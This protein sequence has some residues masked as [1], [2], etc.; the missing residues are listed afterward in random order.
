MATGTLIDGYVLAL[1]NF[2][3]GLNYRSAV[4]HGY[5][6][7]LGMREG[8]DPEAEKIKVFADIVERTVPG[9]WEYARKPTAEQFRGSAVMRIL[10]ERGR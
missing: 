3:T 5:T 1:S 4:V 6:V 8:E 7:P 9:R 2:G 10:I